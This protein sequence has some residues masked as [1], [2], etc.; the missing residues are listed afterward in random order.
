MPLKN[1]K[2][3]RE[4]QKKYYAEH[5]EEISERDKKRYFADAD[6]SRKKNREYYASHKDEI[7]KRRK[8]IYSARSE[9]ILNANRASRQALRLEVISHY[10]NKCEFCGDKNIN[11]LAID[12]IN[13]GGTKH[14]KEEGRDIYRWLKRNNYPDGFRILCHTHN[15]EM[16][17]YGTMTEMDFEK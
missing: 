14:R 7:R 12:H 6:E 9:E 16:G 1:P 5:R 3:R 2:E 10:G 17:F 13:G 15:S 8:E 4:R 11:H